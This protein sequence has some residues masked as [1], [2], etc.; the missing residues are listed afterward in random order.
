[1][2]LYKYTQNNNTA[3]KTK[4]LVMVH[5]CIF[6][7][8]RKAISSWSHKEEQMTKN[9]SPSAG[10]RLRKMGASPSGRNDRFLTDSTMNSR[11]TAWR[12]EF[13]FV[14]L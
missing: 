7:Q 6:E 10:R 12:V 4:A 1:M 14:P 9:D 3:N 5:N 11:S 8:R 2:N 13:A